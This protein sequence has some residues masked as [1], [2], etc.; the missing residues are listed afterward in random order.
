MGVG[1]E[2]QVLERRCFETGGPPSARGAHPKIRIHSQ[3][4][5]LEYQ[6]AELSGE[7]SNCIIACTV[8]F[9]F[10]EDILYKHTCWGV[11][12]NRQMDKGGGLFFALS[13]VYSLVFF[14]SFKLAC[15]TS[16]ATSKGKPVPG[17]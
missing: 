4:T 9:F 10:I 2:G 7:K 13:L 15:V 5:C 17:V 1:G 16:M 14:S 8:I 12:L 3:C 11:S 6:H